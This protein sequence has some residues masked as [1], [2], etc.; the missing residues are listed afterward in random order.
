M[1][2]SSAAITAALINGDQ[3]GILKKDYDAMRMSGLVHIISISGLHINLVAMISFYILRTI[4]ASSYLL[5]NNYNIKQASAFFALVFSSFYLIF[6]NMPSPAVR[7][8]IMTGLVLIAMMLD[9]KANSL[10]NIALA[11]LIILIYQPES[12]LSPSF[13]MSFAAVSVL[14]AGFNTCNQYLKKEQSDGYIRKLIL[15]L[16]AMIISSLLAQL[17]TAPFAIYHFHQFS[18]YGLFA[19]IF[20]IPFSSFIIMPLA[21]ISCLLM[22]LGLENTMLHFLD[23]SIQI[24]LKWAII[25]AKLPFANIDNCFLTNSSFLS[26][27][28]GGLIICICKTKLKYL[29]VI[30]IFIGI[31]GNYLYPLQKPDILI[32]PNNKVIAIRANDQKLYYSTTNI[33]NYLKQAW[34][35][36]NDNNNLNIIYNIKEPL[37]RCVYDHCMVTKNNHKVIILLSLQHFY[38]KRLYSDLIIGYKFI[39]RPRLISRKT[40]SMALNANYAVYINTDKITIISTQNDLETNKLKPWEH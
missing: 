29:G 9:V 40:N 35:Y 27:I 8:F 31:I 28:C 21:I 33:P 19:N 23:Q 37:I 4:F 15:I 20:A 17:A 39:T 12:L 10:R 24:L 1:S 38:H 16:F 32:S 25:I 30:I 22:P 26:I 5:A 14:I 36:N 34:E 6:A 7:S 2:A 18:N 13:Q 3:G 11:A